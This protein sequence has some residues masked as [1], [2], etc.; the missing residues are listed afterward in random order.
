MLRNADTAMYRAKGNGR[1]RI[2]FFDETLHAQAQLRLDLEVELQQALTS[3]QLRLHYQPVRA[4]ADLRTVAVE[5]L[6]RW[7]HPVRGVLGPADFL[8]VA[9]DTGLLGALGD[10]VLS[11]ACEQLG[12]W[13]REGMCSPELSVGVN[14]S[15]RQLCDDGLVTA[16]GAA[17][18]A[19]DIPPSRVCLEMPETAV[20][21]DTGRAAEQL[22]SLKQL[23]V[24]LSLDDFGKGVSSLEVLDRYPLDM[25]KI[26]RSLVERL[27]DGLR[28][29]RMFAS[30]V[31]LA[32][33]STCAWSPRASRRRSSS[34]RSPRSGVTLRKAC[35]S[36]VRLPA[37]LI[38]P[39]LGRAP[40]AA[41]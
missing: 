39:A 36:A 14:L 11:T 29:R 9:E 7:E 2:D 15:M 1:S 41:A 3:G 12:H 26:D 6:L 35:C 5:A 13:R 33:R 4:A 32:T 31:G 16:V 34:P 10:W 23:G 40:M 21:A 24:S 19:A 18:E 17:V 20:A 22:D 38:G 37:A 30:I 28:P 25:L 8:A 27:R